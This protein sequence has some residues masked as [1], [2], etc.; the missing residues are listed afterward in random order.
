MTEEEIYSVTFRAVRDVLLLREEIKD[1][2]EKMRIERHAGHASGLE[3][4]NALQKLI[5]KLGSGNPI[6]EK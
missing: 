6:E 3:D 4:H 1:R 2:E 5:K